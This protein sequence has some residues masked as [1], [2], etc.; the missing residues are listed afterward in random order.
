VSRSPERTRGRGG[1]KVIVKRI[2]KETN[3]TIKYP[4]L[5]R[6]NYDEWSMLMQVNMEAAG[7]WYAVEPYPTRR[8]S[9][10][11]TAWRW[12]P[13]CAPSRQNCC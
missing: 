13:S 8:W 2:V 5:T 9:I 11:T 10:A 6:T 4:T 7:I 3:A 1:P 12:R